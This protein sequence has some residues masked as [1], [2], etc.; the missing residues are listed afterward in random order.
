MQRTREYPAKV[1]RMMGASLLLFPWA[2][3][4]VLG[5]RTGAN[6]VRLAPVFLRLFV[7][8]PLIQPSQVETQKLVRSADLGCKR[9]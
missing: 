4:A 2:Q 8:L 3:G 1:R 5:V 6:I 9:P 7:R